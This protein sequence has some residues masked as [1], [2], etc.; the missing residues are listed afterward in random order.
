MRFPVEQLRKDI[1][2]QPGRRG[3]HWA[4]HHNAAGTMDHPDADEPPASAAL[5]AWQ[6]RLVTEA[7]GRRRQRRCVR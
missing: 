5:R 1:W 3:H 4:L 2:K 7:F 6:S